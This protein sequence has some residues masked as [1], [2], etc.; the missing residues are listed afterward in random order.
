MIVNISPCASSFDETLQVLQFSAIAKQVRQS[1]SVEP[2]Q[3][4][5][6]ASKTLRSNRLCAPSEATPKVATEEED[7]EFD[8]TIA[9]D[10]P[11]HQEELERAED[12][13]EERIEMY[14]QTV[15]NIQNRNQRR[16]TLAGND[17]EDV[18]EN[19]WVPETLLEAEK[20]K[21][22]KLEE[23]ISKLE[24]IVNKNF[25][26]DI[27]V[28]NPTT[29]AH[30]DEKYL[31][32]QL[33]ERNKEYEKK[34]K[35][36]MDLDQMLTEAGQTYEKNQAEINEMKIAIE[37]LSKENSEKIAE[38]Q[39]ELA[40]LQ[41]QLQNCKIQL[42]LLMSST[43][44]NPSPPSVGPEGGIVV[45]AASVN[46][47]LNCSK[48]FENVISKCEMCR[49]AILVKNVNV[50]NMI[51]V[52]D[53]GFITLVNKKPLTS[54][55]KLMFTK[56]SL[57]NE[58]NL[59]Q[60]QIILQSATTKNDKIVTPPPPSD[61]VPPH[62]STSIDG[63]QIDRKKYDDIIVL[64]PIDQPPPSIRVNDETYASEKQT[65]QQQNRDR[66]NICKMPCAIN[67]VEQCAAVTT[68]PSKS[69]TKIK[70]FK[71]LIDNQSTNDR[72]DPS[73]SSEFR[74]NCNNNRNNDVNFSSMV[75]CNK[76]FKLRF[77]ASPIAIKEKSQSSKNNNEDVDVIDCQ[78][79]PAERPNRPLTRLFS[80][81]TAVNKRRQSMAL[82]RLNNVR[83][84]SRK[85]LIRQE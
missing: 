16:I 50:D 25:D 34:C 78:N 41:Q 3:Q 15:K 81:I 26:V 31:V 52:N 17:N 59:L 44:S 61:K 57:E 83:R 77:M 19:N 49:C 70:F 84:K 10:N 36:C 40:N 85:R 80:K 33:E 18:E 28:D 23:K 12:L 22:K 43:Q 9:G 11:L 4:A 60:R 7:D 54:S 76:A 2:D 79:K 39:E 37:R 62:N 45:A 48:V 24:A 65:A 68:G 51:D 53:E 71:P 66:E 73:T 47:K 72:N 32:S 46:G 58:E 6:L 35:E 30:R 55:K 27:D 56:I 75:R 67:K 20:L 82:K 64:S 5:I 29:S 69:N 74:V 14:V 63:R 1:E 8:T 13:A 42:Q 38:L 21:N